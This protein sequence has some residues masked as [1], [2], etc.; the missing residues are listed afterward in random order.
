MFRPKSIGNATRYICIRHNAS[1]QTQLRLNSTGAPR[2][3]DNHEKLPRLPIPS[4]QNLADKYLSSCKPLLSSELFSE[5]ETRVKEFIAPNGLGERLQERLIEHDLKEPNSW[6]EGFWLK[7]A[8]LGWRESLLTNSNWWCLFV[9]PPNQPVD[10]LKKHPPSGVLSSF[11]IQRAAGIISNALT[12]KDLLDS[13]QIPPEYSGSTPLCMNQYRNLFS[14][15]RVPGKY[16]DLLISKHPSRSTHI[17]V[18]TKDQI[19]KVEVLGKNGSR[20]SLKEIERQLYA[21]GQSSLEAA[22]QPAVCILTAAHRDVWFKAYSKLCSLSSTNQDNFKAINEALFAVSL[23]DH[24][25]FHNV[26]ASHLQMFHNRGGRNRWF[27]KAISFIISSSGQ[28]GVN[29]E[30]A[31]ADAVVP[32]NLI[33]FIVSHEPATDP[34]NANTTTQLPA[35]QRLDWTIDDEIQQCISTEIQLAKTMSASI[36][37]CLLHT[38]VYGSRFIKEVAK[39]SPDAYIQLVLQ[40]SYYRQSGSV[41]AVYETVSTRGFKHGRTETVRSMSAETRAFVEAFDDDNILY[42]DK[43][44]L[45]SKAIATQTSYMKQAANGQGID[46]HL[47]GLQSML[48]DEEKTQPSIFNDAGFSVSQTFNLSTSNMSPG[49]LF[50]GGFGPATSDGYGINYAID[51]DEIKFSISSRNSSRTANAFKLR[52]TITRTLVD[53][54]ILFP[55]RTEVWG[56]GWLEKHKKEK[57]DANIFKKMQELSNTYRSNQKVIAARYKNGLGKQN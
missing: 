32:G 57:K 8:Y 5:S 37:S 20:V 41:S 28:A 22:P 38:D 13:Q 18:L 35:P 34:V 42:D 51:T 31:S 29:G 16:E 54:L 25:S 55:K 17:I 48:T 11:Q 21:V 4:L 33:R 9:K 6:L 19:Y 2:T 14:T 50:Y 49:D 40:L 12:F 15:T 44:D 23:D 36:D 10:L 46:R 56:Y 52:S 7:A 3:F 24:A 26:N 43:R 30:H 45:F 1:L 53:M 27:D 47:L 39:T